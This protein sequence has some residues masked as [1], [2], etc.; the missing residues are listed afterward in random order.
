MTF[1]TRLLQQLVCCYDASGEPIQVQELRECLG[2]S[3]SRVET[4]LQALADCRL[5]VATGV[6]TYRPTTTG[7]ELLELDVDGAIV[8]DPNPESGD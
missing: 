3:Q 5:V 6:R 7:R 8:V 4:E 2:A 1:R